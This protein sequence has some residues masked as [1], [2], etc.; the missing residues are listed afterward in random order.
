MICAWTPREVVRQGD[1]TRGGRS[2]TRPTSSTSRTTRSTCWPRALRLPYEEIR[3]TAAAPGRTGSAHDDFVHPSH[4]PAADRAGAAVTVITEELN[5]FNFGDS[6]VSGRA[7]RR[8][9][10]ALPA[11]PRACGFARELG[12]G[13]D[14]FVIVYHG[15]GH[16]AN[17]HELL[18]LYV[19]V[20]LLQRRGRPV[21][22]VR[23]G[24][25]RLAGV[26]P[27]SFR[28]LMDD[29]VELGHVQSWAE[30]PG[31]LALADA[32]V[33]PGAPD[34]FNRYR[35][36][37][38][39]PEFLS[40]GPAGDPARLQPRRRARRRRGCSAPARR[41]RARD[42]RPHR[43]P[44]RCARARAPPRRAGARVRARAPELAA[45][46][47]RARGLLSERARGPPGGR[48]RHDGPPADGGADPRRA[49]LGAEAALRGIRGRRRSPTA[50]C[51]I[52]RTASTTSAA[53][54]GP[55]RT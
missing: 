52:S 11:G 27:R 6:P 41:D 8:R 13:P 44:S 28:A 1:R 43:G 4:Y 14:D 46:R 19:A 47:H 40:H 2:S 50:R 30:V 42:R 25:T 16:F 38:K 33:Q 20:K 32:F 21:K 23:L 37:S 55:I 29:M 17:Q 35:L 31:Y 53:S 5:E 34:E 10:R 45:Q 15:V 36:P 18:S 49:A 48:A 51:A 39:L 12:L 3:Q 24:T 7:P 54:L 26:D 22:L 9:S